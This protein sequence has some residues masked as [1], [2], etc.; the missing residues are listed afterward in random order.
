[1]KFKKRYCLID[2]SIQVKLLPNWLLISL[3][4]HEAPNELHIVIYKRYC[5][6]CLR[7]STGHIREAE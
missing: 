5:Q 1:M 3:T 7:M 6:K 2:Q 4:T